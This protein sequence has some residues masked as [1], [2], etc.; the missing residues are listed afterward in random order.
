ME[1]EAVS[2]T[3]F[4]ADEIASIEK[5]STWPRFLIWPVNLGALTALATQWPMDHWV[6]QIGWTLVA[7]YTFFCL[8][9]PG[10]AL[11]GYRQLWGSPGL[12][13]TQHIHTV[14]LLS[15]THVHHGSYLL[16]KSSDG[17]HSGSI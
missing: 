5:N 11:V 17:S 2:M 14:S 10:Q 4:T 1:T 15:M 12:S 13:S 9:G 16:S 7:A 8:A 3:D 6:F